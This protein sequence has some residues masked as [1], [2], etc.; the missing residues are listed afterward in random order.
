VD[1]LLNYLNRDGLLLSNTVNVYPIVELIKEYYPN[2]LIYRDISFT[3]LFEELNKRVPRAGK[4]NELLNGNK[5]TIIIDLS[6]MHEEPGGILSTNENYK[7]L[8]SVLTTLMPVENL[9]ILVINTTYSVNVEG[10]TSNKSRGGG[11]LIHI[12]PMV[13]GFYDT[14][15]VIKDREYDNFVDDKEICDSVKLLRGFKLKEILR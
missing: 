10:G 15:S 1:E 9:H 5:L 12:F 13:L 6:G 14:I 2:H 3:A 4:L 7:V 11:N 8:C